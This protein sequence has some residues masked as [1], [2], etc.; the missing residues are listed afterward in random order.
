MVRFWK[1]FG[2]DS[3]KDGEKNGEKTIVKIE[4]NGAARDESGTCDEGA[5]YGEEIARDEKYMRLAL[6][7]VRPRSP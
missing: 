6:S 2:A 3:E 7:E 1:Y 4:Q 5:A